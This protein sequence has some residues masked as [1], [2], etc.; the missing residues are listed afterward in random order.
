[1]L[2]LCP[3][4]MGLY[5]TDETRLRRFVLLQWTRDI[6]GIA[7]GKSALSI[8]SVASLRSDLDQLKVDKLYRRFN[9]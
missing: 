3:T 6:R 7:G 5:N 8:V 9:G 2:R 1:M 4:R